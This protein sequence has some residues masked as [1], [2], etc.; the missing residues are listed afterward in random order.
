MHDFDNDWVPQQ[1]LPDKLKNKTY[2]QPK[3]NSKT[4]KQFRDVYQSL[5]S[6]QQKGLS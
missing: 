4:E 5:K 2:F 3:G 1:Y 6:Q